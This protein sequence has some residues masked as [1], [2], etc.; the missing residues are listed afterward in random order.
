MGVVSLPFALPILPVQKFIA[1]SK[2]LG[3]TPR[4]EEHTRLAD[5]PQQ[6]ADMFGW[7]GLARAVA[8][9]YRALP[10]DLRSR[11]AV[12]AGNYGEAGA[13]DFFGP[14][15]GLPHAISGHN[16]YWFWGPRGWDGSV[17][18]VIGGSREDQ[19]HWFES[20]EEV[21]IADSPYA[22]P[23]ERRLPIWLCRNLKVPVDRAWREAKLFI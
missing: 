2:A 4:S 23:Y 16:S 7:E 5:L 9:S 19:L 15:L 14:K 8:E 17:M 1:Y 20:A 18:L 22:M 21:A 13:I 12:Y 10:T 11:C 6:Y 3:R